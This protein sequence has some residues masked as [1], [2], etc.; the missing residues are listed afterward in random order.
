MT[1]SQISDQLAGRAEAVARHLLPN[2]KRVGPEFV[3]GSL[4]GEAGDSLKVRIGGDKIGVWSDFATGQS[5]GDFLDLWCAARNVDLRNAMDE[6]ASYLG[7]TLDAQRSRPQ[8]DYRRPDRPK[9]Y[10]RLDPD[11]P[12]MAYLKSR[13]LTETTLKAFC[14]AEQPGHLRFPKLPGN[15][16]TI[17]FPYLRDGVL[18]NCKYL[19]VQRGDDGKKHTMQEGGCEPCLFGWQTLPPNARAVVITEGEIDAM[20][21]WQHGIP[22][23]SV[24]MGGGGGAKQDWIESDY[25]HLQRFDTILISMD[26]DGPGREGAA[27]IVQRLGEERCRLI[28]LPH[29]DANA[30]LL[31]GWTAADFVRAVSSA[32]SIDPAELK[33]A[34][35]YLGAV[36]HEFF[37]AP[38][39]PQGLETPWPKVGQNL[40]FRT[41]E[42]TI[43]AGYSGH[44]KSLVL[45]HLAAHGLANGEKFCI[46]SMEM[47]AARTLWR[48]VKQLTGRSDPSPAY[49]K[50]SMY[51]LGDKL[52]LFDLMGTAKVERMLAV[53]GY[54]AKRYQIRHFIVDSLAKCGLAEDDYN[55]QK[56][57]VERL[58]DFSHRHE[59]HV[60]LVSHARKGS[61]EHTPP[62]KMDVKGTGAITD[63]ADN[64]ITVWRNKRKEEKHAAA[65]AEERALEPDQLDKPDASLI[66]S[67]QRHTGWEGD[68]WLWFDAHS[69]QYLGHKDQPVRG[70]VP[71]TGDL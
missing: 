43:W 69:L 15:P 37:P 29:K 53:F 30:C 26:M 27:A 34:T 36:L 44:G 39:A 18:L 25:D 48:L 57:I 31:A 62:G 5:G 22:A 46:A 52:W 38:D 12:V 1:P 16:G 65:M 14:I 61:D 6:A 45:N 8:K 67:K 41:A 50:H 23:L 9:E 7:V 28:E 19:A 42:L 55:G 4:G 2:G 70:Y 33:S 54:A 59:A 32:K 71:F 63:M 58:V 11:G 21:Y 3:A 68:I 56:A 49:V 13:G 66:V 51:W 10:R 20:T 35:E 24:P 17:L 60:H 64:V 40:R 47:P